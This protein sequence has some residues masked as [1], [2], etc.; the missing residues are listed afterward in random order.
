[1][2]CLTVTMRCQ[3]RWVLEGN[4]LE[5]QD[6]SDGLLAPIQA[7]VRHY[8]EMECLYTLTREQTQFLACHHQPI[9]QWA[10]VK[11]LL[12]QLHDQTNNIRVGGMWN[13]GFRTKM[14]WWMMMVRW[15]MLKWAC[16]NGIKWRC[17]ACCLLWWRMRW[18]CQVGFGPHLQH[19]TCNENFIISLSMLRGNIRGRRG[20]K[21]TRRLYTLDGESTW[22][23]R[24]FQIHQWKA[25][26]C[27]KLWWSYY[28]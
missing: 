10:K 26:E 1:M 2:W 9:C 27:T 19:A 4:F 16:R 6:W 14:E 24:V 7:D 21:A 13:L 20:S 3:S 28:G 8:P 11:D 23:C 12:Y 22:M 15:L 5:D 17:P 18:L 25:T